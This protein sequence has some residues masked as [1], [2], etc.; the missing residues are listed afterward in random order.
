MPY[1][2]TPQQLEKYQRQR[3]IAL[4]EQ[5]AKKCFRMFRNEST[6]YDHIVVQV[7]KFSKKLEP[8]D[9][10]DLFSNY[11]R[12]LKEYAQGLIAFCANPLNDSL[13]PSEHSKKLNH[14]QMLKNS[15]K[16]KRS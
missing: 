8:F 12:G 3:C 11:Q 10:I 13:N 15:T 14:L 7:E 4:L 9:H 1:K 2:L 16:Y 6:M 5:F